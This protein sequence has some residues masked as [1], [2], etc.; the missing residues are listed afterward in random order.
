NAAGP[1][2]LLYGNMYQLIIQVFGVV[3]VGSFAFVGTYV[4]L[5]VINVL[6]PVRVSPKDEDAGL[7][8][9]QLGEE[10]YTNT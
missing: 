1:N 2:G 5:R 7:D 3:V 6:T 9:T 8:I 4:L 10:A